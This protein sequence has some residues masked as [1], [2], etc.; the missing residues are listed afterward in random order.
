ML[1]IVGFQVEAERIFNIINIYTNLRRN[2]LG[3]DNL[4]MLINI[5]KNWL[6]GAHVKGFPS[7][8]KDEHVDGLPSMEKFME[9]E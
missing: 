4:H 6:N 9:M 2:Q 5:C 7:M 8:D 1:G 3:M